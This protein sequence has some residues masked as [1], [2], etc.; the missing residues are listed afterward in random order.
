MADESFFFHSGIIVEPRATQ[1][2]DF[3]LVFPV[4]EMCS[5]LSN[6]S[7]RCISA[8]VNLLQ[9]IAISVVT[10]TI[11][12]SHVHIHVHIHG[13]NRIHIHVHNRVHIHGSFQTNKN[14][15][16][17]LLCTRPYIYITVHVSY[18]AL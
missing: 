9:S 17:K 15:T 10:T 6:P 16:T 7:D 12:H 8:L 5:H 2:S 18:A 1:R 14:P 11:I 3:R 4:S 13:Y